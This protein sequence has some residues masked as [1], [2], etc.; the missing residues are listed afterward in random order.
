[1]AARAVSVMPFDLN[2]TTHTC[3]KNATG[4]VVTGK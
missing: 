4:G 3:T 2:A 1:V